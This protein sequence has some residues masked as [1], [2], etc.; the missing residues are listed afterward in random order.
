MRRWRVWALAVAISAVVVGQPGTAATDPDT[1]G[2]DG[3]AEGDGAVWD[4]DDVDDPHEV[5]MLEKKGRVGALGGSSTS[6]L[7]RV[8][9]AVNS[10]GDSL[11]GSR[12]VN[13]LA[14]SNLNRQASGGT[15]AFIPV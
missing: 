10:G 3:D 8:L 14:D 5:V 11:V 2:P 15:E 9:W 13:Y 6:R 12:G 1:A 4:A 7:E